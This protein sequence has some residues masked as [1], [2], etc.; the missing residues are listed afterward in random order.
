MTRLAAL[1]DSQFAIIRPGVEARV[2]DAVLREGLLK[3]GLR[4]SYPNITGYQLGIYARTPRSSET[5]ISLHPGADWRFEAGQVFHLYATAQGLALSETVEV[6][7]TGCRR[8]TRTPR[9]IL[10]A[11]ESME[12][13]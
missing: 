10:V 11:G 1:Q 8:L 6:T 13:E 2:A 9:R 5:M 3:A 12:R 4:E 7:E